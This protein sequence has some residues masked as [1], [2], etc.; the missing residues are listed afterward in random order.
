MPDKLLELARREIK[1][2][3]ERQK[4]K[5]N[6]WALALNDRLALAR[7]VEAMVKERDNPRSE[8]PVPPDRRSADDY[9]KGRN[10]A[11]M[12]IVE[13]GTRAAFGEEHD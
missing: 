2:A 8:W 4:G 13:I 7:A 12:D 6:T 5:K 1:R 10:D 9:A 11:T 3:L